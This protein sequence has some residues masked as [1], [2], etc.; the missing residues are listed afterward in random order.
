MGD[1][2]EGDHFHD[3]A[4]Y[5]L[6]CSQGN[7]EGDTASLR[8]RATNAPI[9]PAAQTETYSARAR[10]GA[11]GASAQT[12][13]QGLNRLTQGSAANPPKTR[14]SRQEMIFQT[15]RSA[16]LPDRDMGHL[17]DNG[18]GYPHPAPLIATDR[19]MNVS[20]SPSVRNPNTMPLRVVAISS[21]PNPLK[22]L[23]HA[24]REVVRYF[25]IPANAIERTARLPMSTN[26]TDNR[27]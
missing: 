26:M 12:A 15:T 6:I 27:R 4:W 10:K 5:E 8:K 14:Q 1:R 3:G 17:W 23:D 25:D 2:R 9:A 22:H 18:T 24:K 19:Y 21:L 13:H 20:P 16:R 7:I 11:K